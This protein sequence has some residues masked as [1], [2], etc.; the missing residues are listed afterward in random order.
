MVSECHIVALR[1]TYQRLQCH[2]SQAIR[3]IVD[4]ADFTVKYLNDTLTTG[5]TVLLSPNF[6]DALTL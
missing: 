3:H 1:Q 5:K 2:F 6:F 4:E